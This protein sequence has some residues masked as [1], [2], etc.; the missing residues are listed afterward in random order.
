MITY[1]KLLQE[2]DG[3]G[4]E[5]KEIAFISDIKGLYCDNH[6]RIN[7]KIETDIEKSCILAEELGHYYTSTGDI[8]KQNDVR[9][10]KQEL[11]A[12]AWGYDKKIGLIGIV[13]AFE[14][15]CQNRFE[16]AE[17]LG[18]TEEFLQE[19]IDYYKCKHGKYANIDNYIIFFIPYLQIIKRL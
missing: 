11:R 5:V 15:H 19:A 8:L 13:Q 4:I 18:V 9:N 3:G 6:I 2:A 14:N 7:N 1:E 12:R 10:R 16:M 17:F